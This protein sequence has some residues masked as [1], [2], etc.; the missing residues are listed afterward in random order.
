MIGFCN[1]WFAVK[2]TSEQRATD[3]TEN[4]GVSFL[5]FT[6][7]QEWR[8][9]PFVFLSAQS[10]LTY[11]L[12][13]FIV[14]LVEVSEIT[15]HHCYINTYVVWNQFA[16][17]SK[18]IS[19][20]SGWKRITFGVYQSWGWIWYIYSTNRF[21]LISLIYPHMHFW[22]WFGWKP[23]TWMGIDNFCNYGF[24]PACSFLSSQLNLFNHLFQAAQHPLWISV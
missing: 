23:L 9:D 6:Q 7:C 22:H 17:E 19:H 15:A 8:H 14:C 2:F 12:K 18:K 11:D 13:R 4:K 1:L 5:F 20:R 16:K 10:Y 3:S 21:Y 24:Y